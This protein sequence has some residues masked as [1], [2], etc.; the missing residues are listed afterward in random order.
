LPNH[1][2]VTAHVSKNE[3]RISTL[4]DN[5]APGTTNVPGFKVEASLMGPIAAEATR[6]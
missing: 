5:V 4:P 2:Q 3:M 1:N 6:R